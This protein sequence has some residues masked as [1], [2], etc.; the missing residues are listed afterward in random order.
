[1]S[2]LTSELARVAVGCGR[3]RGRERSHSVAATAAS[4]SASTPAVNSTGSAPGRSFLTRGSAAGAA[5]GSPAALLPGSLAGSGRGA[6]ARACEASAAARTGEGAGRGVG[7]RAGRAGS[8]GGAAVRTEAFGEIDAEG[9]FAGSGGAF[10]GGAAGAGRAPAAGRLAAARAVRIS[11]AVAKRSSRFLCSAL[12]TTLTSAAG[13]CGAQRRTGNGSLCTTWNSTLGVV[14]ASNGLWSGQQFVEHRAR[15]EQVRAPVH[16]VAERLLRRHV[17]RRAEDDALLRHLGRAHA[18]QAEVHDL[19]LAAGSEPDVRRLDVAVDDA[20]RVSVLERGEHAIHHVELLVERAQL[21]GVDGLA[22]VRALE[23]LHGHVEQPVLLPE[24]VDR[25][26]V[27]VVQQGGRLG[28]AL[29]AFERFVAAAEVHGQRLQRDVAVEDGV[30]GLVHLAHGAAAELAHDLV[31]ADPL[32]VHSLEAGR[33]RDPG[34]MLARPAPAGR[35]RR[36][37]A[38]SSTSRTRRRRGPGP[39]G[40]SI[41]GSSTSEPPAPA[42]PLCGS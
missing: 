31:L 22:Q 9:R 17:V 30:V 37:R 5:S 13:V 19:D 34:R 16:A 32:V 25:H 29:E 24:V 1:M 36:R 7:T 21:P 42:R 41:T 20:L 4:S 27:R 3:S 35:Q 11:V 23:Q 39:N 2:A 6:A 10:G 14:S 26:D 38:P 8:G 33:A 40:F 12:S 15:R 18:G 28:L